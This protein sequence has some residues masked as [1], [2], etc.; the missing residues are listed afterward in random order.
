MLLDSACTDYL[1]KSDGKKIVIGLEWCT[2][3][4]LNLRGG[5][6]GAGR[7]RGSNSGS[8][9][10]Q[11]WVIPSWISYSLQGQSLGLPETVLCK[12][13]KKNQVSKVPVS[14]MGRN[15]LGES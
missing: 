11:A 10:R 3:K 4:R 1:F 7:G 2:Q 6:G 5:W 14:L 9:R 12:I 15:T 8:G 13:G